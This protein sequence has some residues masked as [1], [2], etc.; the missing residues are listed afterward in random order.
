MKMKLLF[1]AFLF[2][3]APW[4]VYGAAVDFVPRLVRTTAQ[5]TVNSQYRSVT[6]RFERDGGEPPARTTET[7]QMSESLG[8]GTNGYVYHPNLFVFGGALSGINGSSRSR[9]ST[10]DGD[11]L[12]P[13]KNRSRTEAYNFNGELLRR[14]PLNAEMRFSRDVPFGSGVTHTE[15]SRNIIALHYTKRP[16]VSGLEFVQNERASSN[17]STLD[18]QYR[19]SVAYSI[20]NF[21][22]QGG[23]FY[24]K[25]KS[26]QEN[27][28]FAEILNESNGLS[29]DNRW[30]YKTWN[31][32]TTADWKETKTDNGK[33]INTHDDDTV[34]K[35]AESNLVETVEAGLPWNTN[36]LLNLR[37]SERT[38]HT[39]DGGQT[40]MSRTVGESAAVNLTQKVFDSLSSRFSSTY[41]NSQS[42]SGSNQSKNFYLGTNYI[43]R[44]RTGGVSAGVSQ[45]LTYMDRAGS[46]ESNY[47]STP[48]V[49]GGSFILTQQ[50]IDSSFGAINITI[51]IAGIEFSLTEGVHWTKG[52]VSNNSVEVEL[53]GGTVDLV[54][55][56][57]DRDGGGD[58]T[59]PHIYKAIFRSRDLDYVLETSQQ[60]VYTGLTILNGLVTSQ[61]THKQTAQEISDG[62]PGFNSGLAPIISDDKIAARLNYGPF[63]LSADYQLVKSK[64]DAEKWE[65][66]KSGN[67]ILLNEVW[68]YGAAFYKQTVIIPKVSTAVR[69]NYSTAFYTTEQW[70]NSTDA[71]V[72]L[73]GD[74]YSFSASAHS[75][76]SLPTYRATLSHGLRYDIRRGDYA[77]LVTGVGSNPVNSQ[78]KDV[79]Q[80]N[81]NVSWAVP[82]TKISVTGFADYLNERIIGGNEEISLEYGARSGYQWQF[83][84]TRVNL[85]GDYKFNED[86]IN[87]ETGYTS[88]TSTEEW[89]V[90]LNMT[91]RLF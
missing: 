44:L 75:A 60:T 77:K 56:I 16:L 85:S 48:T 28:L 76:M 21:S 29:F 53:A 37:R 31:F 11:H 10:E 83:G 8:F 90:N 1:F 80:T 42:G 41:S 52:A 58:G 70:D 61:Y 23:G 9:V 65:K 51:D 89:S 18:D 39:F 62:D 34:E 38:N 22:V 7:I 74:K 20:R 27:S 67:P 2:C 40:V 71:S 6:N 43:K 55:Y 54:S 50:D 17:F 30:I 32:K 33:Q 68:E 3:T 81:L 91:R 49:A 79:Y 15:I 35:K 87:D 69:L 47:T 4:I 64:Y 86:E 25:T 45:E 19:G 57:D 72:E 14:K 59:G 46:V 26:K 88:A 82:W 73:S 63:S 5:L 24:A 66:A 12:P 13:A 78:D 36:M 84:A